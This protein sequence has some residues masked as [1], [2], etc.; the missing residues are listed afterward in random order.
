MWAVGI[1]TTITTVVAAIVIPTVHLIIYL[2][3]QY[4]I[5]HSVGLS[6]INIHP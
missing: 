5:Y 3:A 2:K 4:S 1:T 6:H